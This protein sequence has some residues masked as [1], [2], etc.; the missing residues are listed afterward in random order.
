MDL[1]I[2][3]AI[4]V[5]ELISSVVA[6]DNIKRFDA[7]KHFFCPVLKFLYYRNFSDPN[8]NRSVDTVN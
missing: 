8:E 3:R 6:D 7:S 4:D 1:A 5:S 2:Q